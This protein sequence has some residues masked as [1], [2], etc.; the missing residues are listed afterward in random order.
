MDPPVKKRISVI[1]SAGSTGYPYYIGALARLFE[2]TDNR[3]LPEP[4]HMAG[5][6]A[7]ALALASV[8]PWSQKT[9]SKALEVTRNLTPHE[10]YGYSSF[11]KTRLG[12]I[13]MIK[14]ANHFSQE[15]IKKVFRKLDDERFYYLFKTGELTLDG[16]LTT[17]LIY[18]IFGMPSLFS[19]KPLY[20]L[21]KKNMGDSFRGIFNS[22]IKLDVISVDRKTGKQILFTNYLPEHK[23][24][25]EIVR[26]KFFLK[27]LLSSA[28]L[29][30]FFPPVVEGDM[31]LVDGGVV[32]SIPIN[33]AIKINPSPDIV[34][35]LLYK[36]PEDHSNGKHGNSAIQNLHDCYLITGHEAARRNVET[37]MSTNNDL[38]V[39]REL[40]EHEKQKDRTQQELDEF[41]SVIN[42]FSFAGRKRI[43]IVIVQPDK[44]VPNIGFSE[45]N[46]QDLMLSMDIGCAAMDKAIPR[47]KEVLKETP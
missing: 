32:T 28:S 45:F 9:I 6:S 30:G 29:P 33:R 47:I 44:E 35:L 16:I 37:F 20:E 18:E 10:I 31:E 25:D 3:E 19:G 7:G 24:I 36:H 4:Y 2:A 23:N 34:L 21:L 13:A 11:L 5:A 46:K 26:N 27:G 42:K 43:P 40:L 39:L 22:I 8:L 17:L 38:E 15:F 14:I 1:A 12:S 41:N